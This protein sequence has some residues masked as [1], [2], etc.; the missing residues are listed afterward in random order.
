[1]HGLAAFCSI[2]PLLAAVALL[3]WPS[4]AFPQDTQTSSPSEAPET[5]NNAPESEDVRESK[6]EAPIPP[7]KPHLYSTSR[8]PATNR[9][10]DRPRYAKTFDQL[11]GI[12][13]LSWLEAG[14]QVRSRYEYREDFPR[15]LFDSSG[16]YLLRTRGYAG[17]R[18]VTDPL[19]MAFEFQDSRRYD[20]DFNENTRTVNEVD[21][22]QLFGEFYFDDA[23]AAQPLSLRGG[24]MSFD[25]VDRRLMARNR[26]RNTTNA[27]DGGRVRVG[28]NETPW[29][30]D[31]FITRPVERKPR[32][33]DGVD[34]ERTFGGAHSYFRFASIKT[35]IEPYYFFLE[36][37][38]KDPTR[39]DRSIHTIG[40][41]NFGLFGD[42][43]FHWDTDGAFQVGKSGDGD[44]L[45]FAAHAELGYS[46]DLAW[47]PK[48]SAW[49]NYATGDRDPNDDDDDRFDS[50]FGAA[51]TFYGFADAVSWQN[52]INPAAHASA[53]PLKG[54]RLDAFYRAYWLASDKDSFVRARISDP[55]GSSGSFVG[56]EIDFRLR[57]KLLKRVD[58]DLGY[59]LFIAEEFTRNLTPGVSTSELAYAS[60]QLTL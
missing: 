53:R 30:L 1:M 18:G 8:S 33:L 60:I 55:T 45:A 34:D 23:V 57:Y 11:F 12:E 24:R 10:A 42:S 29:E 27:F 41:H 25:A 16:Q 14:A 39:R 40:G 54:L 35:T 13:G 56:Q 19:R 48:L 36:D 22:E 15:E 51:H 7:A 47:K 17:I 5:L 43:G 21:I 31:F 32:E 3:S 58:F 20:S 26:F 52:L 6:P 9:V 44:H 4:F 46:F 50:M 2:A 28:N 38:R 49:F 59:G 37:A